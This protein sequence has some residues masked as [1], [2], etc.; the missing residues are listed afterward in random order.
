MLF[1]MAFALNFQ[2]QPFPTFDIQSN[3][4]RFLSVTRLFV[5]KPSNSLIHNSERTVALVFSF[6]MANLYS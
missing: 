1:L 4:E 3:V 6:S 2:L 5:G